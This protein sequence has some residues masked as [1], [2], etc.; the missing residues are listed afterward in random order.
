MS[1]FNNFMQTP[2]TGLPFGDI[3]DPDSALTATVAG[4]RYP[5]N[6]QAHPAFHSW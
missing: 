3:N 5:L 2:Y 1:L 4:F 6:L